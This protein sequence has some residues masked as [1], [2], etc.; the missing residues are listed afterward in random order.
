MVHPASGYAKV[1]KHRFEGIDVMIPTGY[2]ELLKI[3]FGDYMSFPPLWSNGECGTQI[4]SL[5]PTNLIP[6]IL[7]S[8]RIVE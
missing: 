3:Q 6:T 8:I 2:D 1:E 5:T 4:S 7:N